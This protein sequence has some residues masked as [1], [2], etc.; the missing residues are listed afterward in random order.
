MTCR[1]LAAFDTPRRAL[2][3]HP[4][5]RA[6][7]TIHATHDTT[8]ITY[9][10]FLLDQIDD[11]LIVYKRDRLPTDTFSLVCAHTASRTHTHALTLLLFELKN[12]L[13]ELL[14]QLLVCKVDAQLLERIDCE[15][16]KSTHE[17]E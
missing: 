11:G 3:T 15:I 6:M 9:R 10:R 17:S 8:Q 4:D 1:T 14:L 16:L 7:S 13:I 5:M 2:T 12:R